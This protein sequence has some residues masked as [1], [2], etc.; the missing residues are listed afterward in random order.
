MVRLFHHAE[1]KFQRK[2]QNIIILM[3]TTFGMIFLLTFLIT[4]FFINPESKF[5]LDQIIQFLF[6][7]MQYMF[8]FIEVV[9]GIYGLYLWTGTIRILD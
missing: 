8:N 7:A 3:Y 2:R 1:H 5:I 9:V 4:D 6:S